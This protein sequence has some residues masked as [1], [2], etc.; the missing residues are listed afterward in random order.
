MAKKYFLNNKK[1]AEIGPQKVGIA[2]EWVTWEVSNLVESIEYLKISTLSVIDAL[3]GQL[4]CMKKSSNCLRQFG[5]A[6]S[7]GKKLVI[8][9]YL[10]PKLMAG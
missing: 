4:L 5:R 10:D 1:W 6:F 7:T 3:L 9:D 8:L 2:L